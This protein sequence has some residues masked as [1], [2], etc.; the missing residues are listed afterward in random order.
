[1]N[2]MGKMH[3]CSAAVLSALA[4]VLG[5]CTIV[6][7]DGMER[8]LSEGVHRLDETVV[9]TAADSG[10]V[11]KADPERRAVL[12]G[13][14]VVNS[15][16]P[17]ERGIYVADVPWVTGRETGFRH[18]TVNGTRRGRAKHPN[19]DYFT[20]LPC[21]VNT[22]NSNW[23]TFNHNTD[24]FRFRING[25][26]INPK[27]NLSKGEVI[28]Y[29]YW[30]DSHMTPSS[31]TEEN[32]TNF[33]NLA[34]SVKR[35]PDKFPWRLE[36]L[37]EIVDEPGEWAVDYDERKLYYMP[38]P[39]EDMAKAVVEVPF[40][41]EFVRLDGARD[42]V[43]ENIDFVDAGFELPYGERSAVQA[44]NK[45]GASVVVTNSSGCV[46]RNCRFENVDGYA[47]DFL[48]GARDNIV[49]HCTMKNL[50]AG[51][52]R[53][54]GADFRVDFVENEAKSE[55]D[56]QMPDPRLVTSGNTVA[57]CEIGFYGLSFPAAVG[58]IVMAAER[59]LVSH[60]H[61][62]DGYYTG[63]SIGWKWGY[64]ASISRD[65]IVEFNHIH[66]IGKGL[67]SDMGGIYTL[68]VSPGTKLVN[69]LIHDVDARSYGGWG[70]YNDEGSWGILL[71]DNVVYNTKYCGYHM[72]FGRDCTV[73]NNIFGG[74][75]IDQLARSRREEHVSLFFYNNIVYWTEGRLHT[76]QWMD[77]ARYDYKETP[78]SVRRPK[79]TTSSDYNLFYNPNMKFEDVRWGNKSITFDEWKK[80]TCNDVHSVYADPMFTDVKAHDFTLKPGSPALAMGFRPIDVSTV[81][82]RKGEE[83][84]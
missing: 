69:N 70:L 13:A 6:D 80:T 62:H 23:T 52:V 45:V 18:I 2:D 82:P 8:V 22:N 63:V 78:W 41:R 29:H 59:S 27:W 84:K 77:G 74:G 4:C 58:V 42:V 49:S 7:G 64:Q 21:Y 37:V 48:A 68:G 73:R 66:D 55:Y 56:Y 36:N 25:G 12:S 53:M 10:T 61:I 3:K 50:G 75:R 33:L 24:R 1:M 71:E 14:K 81:G 26:E 17:F 47:I 51:G 79:R 9:F 28:I 43:F 15:W 11:W 39:G 54:N 67:L 20:S 19:K 34:V 65:N 5:G 30:T 31:V 60:N 16:R 57:D 83:S 44:A 76:G 35:N 40:L 72:H 46:F 32:G 38:L